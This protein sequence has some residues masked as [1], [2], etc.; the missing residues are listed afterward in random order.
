MTE[1]NKEKE[2]GIDQKEIFGS[3]KSFKLVLGM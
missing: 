1:K 3:K 2:Y